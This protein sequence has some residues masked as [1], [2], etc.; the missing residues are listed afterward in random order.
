MAQ[1]VS[2]QASSQ[3]PCKFVI[4]KPYMVSCKFLKNI[5]KSDTFSIHIYVY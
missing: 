1:A 5:K 4:S 3:V 2:Q